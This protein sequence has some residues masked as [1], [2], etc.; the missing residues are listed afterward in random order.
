MMQMRSIQRHQASPP[1]CDTSIPCSPTERDRARAGVS[2]SERAGER[3]SE[4]VRERER[5]E[6]ERERSEREKERG[7]R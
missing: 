1:Y 5:G 2:Q 7:E 4:R 3:A 6:G